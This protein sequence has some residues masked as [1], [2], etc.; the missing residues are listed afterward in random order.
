MMLSTG[1][2]QPRH[3]SCV[4]TLIGI[5]FIVEDLP[6]PSP[7]HTVHG[8]EKILEE[9]MVNYKPPSESNSTTCPG[10]FPFFNH[11]SVILA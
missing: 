5:Y 1:L 2:Q 9:V 7:T 4:Y 11:S 6:T 8:S 10:N 3:F